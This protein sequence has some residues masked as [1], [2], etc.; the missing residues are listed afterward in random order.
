ME[1]ARILGV[2]GG[3][4]PMATAYFYEMITD[5]TKAEKDQDHIDMVISSRVTTPDRTAYIMGE[6]KENPLVYMT[7]DAVRLERY[8][9]DAIVIP[10]NTAHYFYEQIAENCDVPI[11]NII[12]ETVDFCNFSIPSSRNNKRV[13]CNLSIV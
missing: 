2:L 4:G 6:S 12:K 8:G 1:G 13:L 3:L 11:I 5:H 10:C 7:E 9:A